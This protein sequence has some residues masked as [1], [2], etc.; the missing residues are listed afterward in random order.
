MDPVT[1]IIP[2]IGWFSGPGLP[3]YYTIYS[4]P[5]NHINQLTSLNRSLN[6]IK[7]RLTMVCT[8]GIFR[9]KPLAK[10]IKPLNQF[11]PLK[12]LIFNEK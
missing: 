12:Y 5:L 7:G 1:L 8:K 6:H 2:L 4:K 9:F 3:V 11:K 10:V